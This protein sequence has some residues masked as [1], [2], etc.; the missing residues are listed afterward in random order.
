VGGRQVFISA[1]GP[2]NT[3]LYF[4][5]SLKLQPNLQQIVLRIASSLNFASTALNMETVKST[6]NSLLGT[7]NKEETTATEHT[8]TGSVDSK[9]D[10]STSTTTDSSSNESPA[11]TQGSRTLEGGGDAPT[12]GNANLGSDLDKTLS[13]PK[14][15]ALQGEEHPKMTGTGAPG[16]HSA[17]FG[18]TPDG[19]KES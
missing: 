8:S 19:K 13:G 11:T 14:D 3:Q 7:G 12:K 4:V 9:P 10:T 18:L 2:Q 1:A 5:R 6:V 15:P 16:S 17:I